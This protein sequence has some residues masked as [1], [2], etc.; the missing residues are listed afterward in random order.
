MSDEKI[1]FGASDKLPKGY[2]RF[3]NMADL[4]NSSQVKRYGRYKVDNRRLNK[5][6]HPENI[7]KNKKNK[8]DELRIKIY[9]NSIRA[10]TK[11]YES[12]DIPTGHDII[13]YNKAY[14]GLIKLG[15]IPKFDRINFDKK[16]DD[17]ILPKKVERQIDKEI[18]VLLKKNKIND[19]DI[20]KAEE[21][22]LKYAFDNPAFSKGL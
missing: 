5:I 6:F 4:I 19:D 8:E 2:T 12:G 10:V 20:L 17:I 18:D 16:E 7:K 9:E 14:D 22:L 15:V 11:K 21:R 3:A 13:K 1:Y